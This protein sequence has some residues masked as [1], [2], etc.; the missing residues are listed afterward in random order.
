MAT[1]EEMHS[2]R[3]R[4]RLLYE[5]LNGNLLKEGFADEALYESLELCLSCKACKSECPASI[6]MSAYKAE[7]LNHYYQVHRRPLQAIFFGRIHDAARAAAFAP[8]LANLFATGS[9]AK[10]SRRLL[11]FHPERQL[12]QFAAQ[13]F[14][15]WFKRHATTNPSGP[16]VL[17]FPDTFTNFFEPAVAIAATEAIERAGFRV[18]IPER[19]LCCG[20]PMQ[21]AGMLDAVRTRLAAVVEAL[22]PYVQRGASIV[23]VEPSCLLTLRDELPSMFPH[24][25]DARRVADHALLFDEFI[26]AKAPELVP[27]LSGHA[28]VHG[29]C[30]QKALAGM[31]GELAI[32]GR[33]RELTIDTPDTG[34]CGMAGAFGWG[35]NRFELSRAIGERVLLP[36]IRNSAP[37][38]LIVA[39][40]FA[41]R[42]QI[43]QFCPDRRPVHLAQA[44]CS[45]PISRE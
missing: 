21:E 26:A 37:E 11:G 43:R 32:L 4:A 41:C 8:R 9:F 12:P 3:G 7:F 40:G 34:C 24:S 42:T 10:N 30:H 13:S 15:K 38:S 17:L 16:E 31:Q 22:N 20:R 28:L 6:D 1:R 27:A 45:A 33:A 39:D 14:R 2:T 29:H 44:L 25:T 35:I 19:D 23:G 18:V 36:A 5:A